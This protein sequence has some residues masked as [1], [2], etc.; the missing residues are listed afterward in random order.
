[1]AGAPCWSGA[2]SGSGRRGARWR[3]RPGAPRRKAARWPRRGRGARRPT[4]GRPRAGGGAEKGTRTTP[5]P[6]SGPAGSRSCPCMRTAVSDCLARRKKNDPALQ[7]TDWDS[8]PTTYV[9]VPLPVDLLEVDAV[10]DDAAPAR[11]EEHVAE[12]APEL[13]GERPEAEQHEQEEDPPIGARRLP[14]P[15]R[16]RLADQRPV[17]HVLQAKRR[18]SPSIGMAQAHAAYGVVVAIAPLENRRRNRTGGSGV[19]C[20]SRGC[21]TAR[22]PGTRHPCRPCS[23]QLT[24]APSSVPLW[25]RVDLLPEGAKQARGAVRFIWK[26]CDQARPGG[27]FCFRGDSS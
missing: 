5:W 11:G 23:S 19:P 22:K 15:R 7:R 26:A 3:G 10:A 25:R 2:A 14:R 1:M 20:R 27:R 9:P 6:P 4:R 17:Q 12:G 16:S 24:P 8:F 21:P 13:I 18:T